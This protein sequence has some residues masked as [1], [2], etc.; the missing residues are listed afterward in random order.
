MKTIK[1]YIRT[2]PDFPIKGIQ[3]RD[4]TTLVDNADGFKLAVDTMCDME[5][6][7]DFDIIAGA[8]SRGFIFAAPM[9]YNMHKPFVL[10]RKKGKLPFKTISQSYDLEYGSTEIE[11]HTD[12]F[13]PGAKVLIVDDLI[14]TGGTTKAMI[15]LVEKLGGVVA[16]VCVLVEL[17]DLKGRER[18]KDYRLDSAVTYEGE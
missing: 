10:I 12:S 7:L 8:E 16:G 3:F 2:I 15:K 13:K 18:I 9:A 5:K 11:M 1:D 4:I 6:D 17:V 14:A